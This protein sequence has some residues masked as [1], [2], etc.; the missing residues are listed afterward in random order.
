MLDL[1]MVGFLYVPDLSFCLSPLGSK[2]FIHGF[3]A[4]FRA[5]GGLG[6]RHNEHMFSFVHDER[7]PI[8]GFTA[9]NTHMG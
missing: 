4:F 5:L 9:V 6:G 2:V 7:V 1:N 8:S 3:F